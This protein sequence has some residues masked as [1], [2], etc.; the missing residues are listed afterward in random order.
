MSDKRK[1]KPTVTD[2]RW[3][4]DGLLIVLIFLIAFGVFANSLSNGF[5]YD[6]KGIIE[7]N[8][9]LDRPWD[10][11]TFFN[12]SYWGELL[13]NSLLYRPLTVMSF[14]V[15]RA[16]FGP[17]PFGVHLMN[18]LANSAIA[19]L[20]YV[21]LLRLLG[22][23]DVALIAALL[24]AVHPVH[25][26]VVANGAG[27]SE[28]Y[29]VLVMLVAL[30]LHLTYLQ[31]RSAVHLVGAVILYLV[32]LLLKE[33]AAVLPGLL[34]LMDWLVVRRGR[35]PRIGAYCFYAVPLAV[36]LV[37]RVMVVGAG[38]PAVQEVM[39]AASTS[40]RLLYA[41]ETMLRYLGQLVFPLQLCA[42][43]A[44]YTNLIRTTL[45]DSVVLASLLTWSGCVLIAIWLVRRRQYTLLFAMTWFFL[46]LIPVSNL[47]IPIGTIRADRLLF[48]PSLGF[49]LIL[50][51]F[52][53]GL[54]R[55]SRWP[56]V[57]LTT[58]VLS[59]Y[60]WRT[61]ERNRDWRSEE[62]LWTVTVRDNPGSAVAWLGLGQVHE[63]RAEFE[64]AEQA[65]QRSWELR[66]GAGFFY[67]DAH[68]R[69]AQ[70]LRRRGART[71]AAEHYCLVLE[72]DPR[73]RVALM[74]LGEI[75]FRDGATRN[76]AIDLFQRAITEQPDDFRGY[77]NL[78]QAYKLA[79]QFEAA[80]TAVNAALRLNPNDA[81]LWD[82]KADILR[83]AGRMDAARQAQLQAERLRRED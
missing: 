29:A 11:P 79:G 27:R 18:V 32:A 15:D 61:F 43:Y 40:Q 68:N 21:F 22:R 63:A 42:E 12:T 4:S 7:Q 72:H 47:I 59:L 57:V 20:I 69:Y 52:G 19:V 26:E 50:A 13:P 70:M 54:A 64:Q 28:L 17:G 37:A 2:W 83:L 62:T 34:F 38:T 1:H 25:T 3:R 76:E 75:L 30:G 65:Y 58:L 67:P 10:L 48:L 9:R 71:T 6:D 5:V 78:A 16:L 39:L 31:R 45:T 51:H 33:S 77:V 24:F 56:A 66:D 74:N 82:V 60:A 36:Y 14:A 53:A 49:V 23:R 44:D 8:S 35:L 73:D 46:T 41:S 80:L 81:R 55:R